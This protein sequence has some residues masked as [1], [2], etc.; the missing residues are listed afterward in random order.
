MV[1]CFVIAGKYEFIESVG[2]FEG[3]FDWDDGSYWGTA[4][5]VDYEICIDGGSWFAG[6]GLN[7][8]V[9]YAWWGNC[10]YKTYW[11]LFCGWQV[12]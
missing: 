9:E 2:A 8:F 5:L 11:G 3:D 1:V 10:F 4:V 6:M 12:S 7:G